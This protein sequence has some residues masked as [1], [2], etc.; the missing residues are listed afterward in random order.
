L[1][2]RRSLAEAPP[3]RRREEPSS[4]QVAETVLSGMPKP[5]AA[6]RVGKRG[7]TVWMSPEAFRQLK[8]IAVDEDRRVHDLLIEALNGLFSSRRKPTFD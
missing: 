5:R 3:V 6:A 2:V 4:P 8:Q 7:A 1:P